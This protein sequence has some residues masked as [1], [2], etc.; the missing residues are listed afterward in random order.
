[1]VKITHPLPPAIADVKII[2]WS[3]SSGLIG[4][5]FGKKKLKYSIDAHKYVDDNFTPLTR[6]TIKKK[7]NKVYEKWL[8]DI[9]SIQF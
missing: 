3:K 5:L 1:M 6:S 8:E 2:V 7:L 4:K 9:Q